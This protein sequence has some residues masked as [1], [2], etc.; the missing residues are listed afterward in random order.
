MRIR[1]INVYAA[2]VNAPFLVALMNWQAEVGKSSYQVSD[3][4]HV[5]I[6]ITMPLTLAKNKRA[7]L[8]QKCHI[9]TFA[10]VLGF[11]SLMGGV[12]K[13]GRCLITSFVYFKT[14]NSQ[15]SRNIMLGNY[16]TI[17]FEWECD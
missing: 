15:T 16:P 14:T 12:P 17:C 11:I 5:R 8:N 6:R 3:L 2:R 7:C 4:F 10:R 13:Y 9:F 1:S